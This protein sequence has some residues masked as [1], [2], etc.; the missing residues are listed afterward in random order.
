MTRFALGAKCGALRSGGVASESGEADAREDGVRSLNAM[1]PRPS[2]LA[3]RKW[4]RVVRSSASL[5]VV[6]MSGVDIVRSNSL[7]A[8][9]ERITSKQSGAG[10]CEGGEFGI[11]DASETRGTA[12]FCSKC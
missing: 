7:A 12:C 5:V 4:R 2:A 1:A 10:E 11:F 9:D 3:A 6:M 8:D